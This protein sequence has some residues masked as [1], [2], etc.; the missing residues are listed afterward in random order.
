MTKQIP[1]EEQFCSYLK[2]QREGTINML[3]VQNGCA[4]T[5]LDPDTYMACITNYTELRKRHDA[6]MAAKQKS[7]VQIAPK[8]A[9]VPKKMGRIHKN[10]KYNVTFYHTE[11]PGVKKMMM[12]YGEEGVTG[13]SNIYDAVRL[14]PWTLR[15]SCMIVTDLSDGTMAKYQL[16][17]EPTLR[18]N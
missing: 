18:M 16:D 11:A 3:D 6:L 9:P 15:A 5:G 10:G 1:T 12:V 2:L 7:A 14:L 17:I 8:P 4:L 13:L